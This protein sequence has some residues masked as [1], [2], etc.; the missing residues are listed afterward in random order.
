MRRLSST[1]PASREYIRE[2]WKKK[3]E[4]DPTYEMFMSARKR[5]K[6]KQLE[7]DIDKSDI[8]IPSV[9]PVLNIPVYIS[10][11][12]SSKNS[13]CLDRIDNSKGYTKDNIRVI[14]NK[15]NHCKSDLSIEEVENLLKYMK[16][17]I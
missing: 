17:Q 9:C 6:A 3:R 14:S 8:V 10:K 16:G 4:L 7:F 1:T 11:G 5:A 13:P 2:W 15:A 12:K